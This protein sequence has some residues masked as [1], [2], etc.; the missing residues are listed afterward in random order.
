MPFT[1]RQTGYFP[2]LGCLNASNYSQ[3]S[4][5]V[6]L[7]GRLGERVASQEVHLAQFSCISLLSPDIRAPEFH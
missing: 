7:K 3:T 1:I 5:K 6:I 2:T 4:V